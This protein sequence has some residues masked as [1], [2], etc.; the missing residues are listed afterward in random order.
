[1]DGWMYSGV[2]LCCGKTDSKDLLTFWTLLL[3]QDA[4]LRLAHLA[5]NRNYVSKLGM[6]KKH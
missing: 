2:W 4:G 6:S 5:V 1:M 3:E